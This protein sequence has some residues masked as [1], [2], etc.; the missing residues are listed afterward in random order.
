MAHVFSL[1]LLLMALKMETLIASTDHYA[2]IDTYVYIV[3]P[4]E[5]IPQDGLDTPGKVYPALE[6][7]GTVYVPYGNIM[8]EN[9]DVLVAHSVSVLDLAARIEA[10]ASRICNLSYVCASTYMHVDLKT[11][12]CVCNTGFT[13]ATCTEHLCYNGGTWTGLGCS[14]V[15]PY[16][17][18]SLC[19]NAYCT[20]NAYFDAASRQCICYSTVNTTNCTVVSGA[21][22]GT[23]TITTISYVPKNIDCWQYYNGNC[24]YRNNWGV[25]QCISSMLTCVCAP[26]YDPLGNYVYKTSMTHDGSTAAITYFNK[27]APVCC[28]NTLNCAIYHAS[29]STQCWTQLCCNLLD[30]RRCVMKGCAWT[31]SNGCIWDETIANAIGNSWLWTTTRIDCNRDKHNGLCNNETAL[32]QYR[33]YQTMDPVSA[34]NEVQ[35]HAWQYITQYSDWTGS[36][37]TIVLATDLVPADASACTNRWRLSLA[38][39]GLAISNT[40]WTCGVL[41]ASTS[42]FEFRIVEAVDLPPSVSIAPELLGSVYTI[43]LAGTAWCL[44]SRTLGADEQFLYSYALQYNNNVV[45]INT[46]YGAAVFAD[47][48]ICGLWIVSDSSIQS[49][50][51][52]GLIAKGPAVPGAGT[53]LR[54][55]GQ[56]QAYY[57]YMRTTSATEYVTT[58]LASSD[59]RIIP[60]GLDPIAMAQCRRLDCQVPYFQGK[61]TTTTASI[62]AFLGPSLAAACTPCIAAHV[63]VQS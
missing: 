30:P 7:K 44:L 50:D 16:T 39:D 24:T 54:Y 12:T 34:Y 45:A 62:V 29:R 60:L 52:G 32:T 1:F 36:I 5:S 20:F 28:S 63:S 9:G 22:A 17:A 18:E 46:L 41:V 3:P 13:G 33:Y 37:N 11:C 31:E 51:T 25:S 15:F 57:A 49:V 61:I 26:L 42:T 59:T 14:C 47:T 21:T 35:K 10:V 40:V 58:P 6:A 23:Q 4:D 19:M 55:P 53:A 43:F 38:F 56:G 2:G 48:S 8:V 27:L